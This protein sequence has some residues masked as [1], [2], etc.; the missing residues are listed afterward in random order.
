MG[1]VL[2]LVCYSGLKPLCR[3]AS[4]GSQSAVTVLWKIMSQGGLLDMA[5]LSI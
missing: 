1:R 5:V 4:V 3:A 2:L